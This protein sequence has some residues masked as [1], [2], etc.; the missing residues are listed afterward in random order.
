MPV[1]PVAGFE[2]LTAVWV[3]LE[4]YEY[5]GKVEEFRNYCHSTLVVRGREE[6][7]GAM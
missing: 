2:S 4:R 1:A 7:R 5:R 6:H 3:Q